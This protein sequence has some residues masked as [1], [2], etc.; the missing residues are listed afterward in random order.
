MFCFSGSLTSFIHPFCSLASPPSEG[1][2]RHN[3]DIGGSVSHGCL[4][5][6]QQ[7]PS[8][9][10]EGL[11]GP[12]PPRSPPWFST[13]CQGSKVTTPGKQHPTPVRDGAAEMGPGFR[14][15]PRKAVHPPGPRKQPHTEPPELG[16]SGSQAYPAHGQNR[17]RRESAQR[18]APG[19][20]AS[21]PEAQPPRKSESQRERL[22]RAILEP[23]LLCSL[24]QLS[25][26]TNCLGENTTNKTPTKTGWRSRATEAPSQHGW[27]RANWHRDSLLTANGENPWGTVCDSKVLES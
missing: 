2:L 17:T 20:A 5:E 8:P 25:S 10:G 22:S 24:L 11:R 19:R 13:K 16:S 21:L 7:G 4:P 18:W 12:F 26:R 6:S 23:W 14:A 3:G 1:I 9:R 27:P 15:G